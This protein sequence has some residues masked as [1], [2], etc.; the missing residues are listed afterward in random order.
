[1]PR[2]LLILCAFVVG[3][4]RAGQPDRVW[5]KRGTQDGDFVR[6]RAAV[7][8]NRDRLWVVDFTARVQAYDLD[9][10]HLGITFRTPDFRNGRPSG[11]GLSRDGE[12][13]VCDS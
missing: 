9:G 5:G 4:S 6:P 2:R 12:L 8:D 3:C 7:I 11:L 10:L 1:M 13:I